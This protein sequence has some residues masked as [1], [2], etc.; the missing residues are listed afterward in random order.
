MGAPMYDDKFFTFELLLS[1]FTLILAPVVGRAVDWGISKLRDYFFNRHF[2]GQVRELEL[3]SETIQKKAFPIYAQD[4]FSEKRSK[5]LKKLLDDVQAEFARIES[6]AIVHVINNKEIKKKCDSEISTAKKLIDEVLERF[7]NPDEFFNDRLLFENNLNKLQQAKNHIFRARIYFD[8]LGNG[9]NEYAFGIIVAILLEIII[10]FSLPSEIGEL[11]LLDLIPITVLS[12]GLLGGMTYSLFLYVK[13]HIQKNFR[14]E[15]PV[16]IFLFNPIFSMIM[17]SMLYLA[18]LTGMVIVGGTSFRTTTIG[19]P[20]LVAL[21]SFLGG[22]FADKTVSILG[23][24]DLFANMKKDKRNDFSSND[25]SEN[26][27]KYPHK[28]ERKKKAVLRENIDD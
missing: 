4:S 5:K 1:I 8:S 24:I 16:K 19:N 3:L 27:P 7:N 12:M 20:P 15:E 25:L 6:L 9:G 11:K 18:F 21:I 2:N 13:V 26:P 28:V 17:A 14:I 10:L 23:N 22:F